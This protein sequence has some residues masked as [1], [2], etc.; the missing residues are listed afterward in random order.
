MKGL[1]KHLVI[2]SQ[3]R[4]DGSFLIVLKGAPSVTHTSAIPEGKRVIVRD[5]KVAEVCS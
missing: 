2:R 1:D 4:R 3:E 5:G